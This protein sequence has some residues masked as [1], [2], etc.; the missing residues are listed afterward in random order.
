MISR[1]L[2]RIKILQILYAHF[3]TEDSGIVKSEK[4][5][6][7]SIQ[8]A[9]DLYFYLLLL[10]IAVKRYAESRIE[11]ARN[12]KLPTYEDLHPNTRFIENEV[13]GQIEE[14]PTFKQYTGERKMSWANHPELIKNL[15]NKLIEAPY[16]KKYME[17]PACSYADDRQLLIDFYANELEDYDM[18]YEILEEQSIFWNDD[19]EFVVIMVTKTIKDMRPNKT[20]FLPLYKSDDDREFA[21]RL[22]RTSIIHHDEYRKLIEDYVDNWDIERV[23]CIDNLI[24]QIAINE[25]IEFP[26]I[27]VKVTFDEY[28]ELA[29]YYSTPKS[30][31]FINGLLDKI[32]AD[33]TQKGK[34]TKTG[35]GLITD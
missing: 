4:D 15:Y 3:N 34:I 30:S 10:V 23:A 35:R 20:S 32:S 26:S 12:K 28:L 9:Y 18:F 33:L 14:S 8:K 5:L 7:F 31:V 25:L 21:Y 19:I 22:L 1:R 2:L 13:I 29:K 27:P 16:Y 24:M 17:L 6:V 11:L